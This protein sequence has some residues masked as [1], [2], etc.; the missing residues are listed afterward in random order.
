[1][2]LVLNL[3]YFVLQP[4]LVISSKTEQKRIIQSIRMD[5]AISLHH[6]PILFASAIHR[7]GQIGR[8]FHEER[9]TI[10]ESVWREEDW[11]DPEETISVAT[12]TAGEEEP[13]SKT[14][15]WVL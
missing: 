8:V 10:P 6:N 11:I 13:Q 12:T 5:T 9:A 1:M 14:I 3:H 15:V 7:R 2:L 4:R